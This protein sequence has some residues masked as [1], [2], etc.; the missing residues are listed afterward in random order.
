MSREDYTL[1]S[2]KKVIAGTLERKKTIEKRYSV[3]MAHGCKY[4]GVKK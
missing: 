2:L 3:R 1:V 4:T